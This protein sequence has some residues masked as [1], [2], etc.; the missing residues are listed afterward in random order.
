MAQ[1][2]WG[3]VKGN[4]WLEKV[5]WFFPMGSIMMVN[6]WI[7]IFTAQESTRVM[8]VSMRVTGKK[9]LKTD[10]EVKKAKMGQ[11]LLESMKMDISKDLAFS[12]GLTVLIIKEC[13]RK[14]VSTVEEKWFMPMVQCWRANGNRMRLM[15]MGVQQMLREIFT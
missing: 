9:V 4:R 12:N 1:S 15:G 8:M 2:T 5:S 6:F 3:Y 14:I 13:L 7:V 10:M 11:L